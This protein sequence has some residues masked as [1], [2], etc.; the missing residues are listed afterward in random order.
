MPSAA[1]RRILGQLGAYS[2]WANT[3]D[4]AARTAKARAAADARFE[5]EVDPNNE[6]LPEVRAKKAEAAR[7]AFYKRMQ[8]ASAKARRARAK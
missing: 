7:K 6:L 8:L 2:S 4:R 5:R 3:V 1:E